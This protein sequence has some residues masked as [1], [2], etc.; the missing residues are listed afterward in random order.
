ML[1]RA[2]S[3]GNLLVFINSNVSVSFTVTAN[4][5]VS[6]IVRDCPSVRAIIVVIV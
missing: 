3:I 1:K 4:V 5:I 2:L 6:V